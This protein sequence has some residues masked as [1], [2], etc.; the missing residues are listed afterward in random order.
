VAGALPNLR[1]LAGGS[2][3][4]IEKAIDGCHVFLF[5]NR[6]AQARQVQFEPQAVGLAAI[7]DA[8]TGKTQRLTPAAGPHGVAYSFA[9]PIGEIRFVVIAPAVQPVGALTA[10]WHMDA[11]RDWP[12]SIVE[13]GSKGWHLIVHGQ[14][15]GAHPVNLELEMKNLS[16]W[17]TLPQLRDVSGEGG[18]TTDL[19]V[20]PGWLAPG[21]RLWLDLGEQ[22]DAAIVEINSVIIA[23]PVCAP[24]LV[25]MTQALKPGSNVVKVPV[26]TTPNN[27]VA[28]LGA[29]GF[30]LHPAGLVGPVWLR[31]GIE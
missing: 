16:D 8:W 5:G 15:A 9:L 18:Y 20:D 17:A 2:T 12:T 19:Q 3:E 31:M 10:D 25:V 26:I 11:M 14:S 24:F 6:S 21:R 7:W 27:S 13:L 4:F 30:G 1:F 28:M 23:A 29:G 22:H